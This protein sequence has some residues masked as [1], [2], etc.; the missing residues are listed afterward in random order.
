MTAA[1]TLY[2]KPNCPACTLTKKT[3]DREGIPHE[4]RDVT[5]DPEANEFV[6]SL[7]YKA[8]PVVHAGEDNHWSGFRPERIRSL[9]G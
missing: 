7:G 6:T 1:V 5:T 8:A 4:M 3:L 9:S 2:T